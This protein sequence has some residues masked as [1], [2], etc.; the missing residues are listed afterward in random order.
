MLKLGNIMAFNDLLSDEEWNE[1]FQSVSFNKVPKDFI[2]IAR[3][4]FLNGKEKDISPHE[5][6]YYVDD[7][8]V[9]Q[10]KVAVDVLKVKSTVVNLTR[11][12]LENVFYK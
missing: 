3:V 11:R 5:I 7:P 12:V 10:V 4:Y 6:E 2:A 9:E 8:D 1:I